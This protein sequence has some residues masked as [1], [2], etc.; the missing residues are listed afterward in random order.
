M[1]PA[2]C[3][4]CGAVVPPDARA[5]PECGADD[6]TGWS[7][8]AYAPQPD[9]PDEEFDYDEFAKREFSGGEEASAKKPVWWILA[10]IVALLLIYLL[11]R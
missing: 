9:L 8:T 2:V 5:C 4:T 1:P 7:E 6:E 3:P 10:A 11:A